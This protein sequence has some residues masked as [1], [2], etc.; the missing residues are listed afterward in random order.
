MPPPSSDFQSKG[1]EPYQWFLNFLLGLLWGE[2]L[3][4]D[5]RLDFAYKNVPLR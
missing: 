4:N 2:I 3:R 5:R 1:L